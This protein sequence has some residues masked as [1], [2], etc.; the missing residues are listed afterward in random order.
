MSTIEH[1]NNKV[2]KIRI[3]QHKIHDLIKKNKLKI[4]PHMAFGY[5]ALSVAVTS[6]I[7]KKKDRLCLTHRN[8]SYNL[9]LTDSLQ[10]I[11]DELNLKKSGINNGITGS[12]NIINPKRGLYYTSSIL[13]NNLSIA[14]GIALQN[15]YKNN[16]V[17]FVTTGDGSMEE[18]SFYEVLLLART[19]NLK[20]LIIIENNNYAMASTIQDRRINFNIKKL[21]EALDVGYYK[22]QGN[23]VFKYFKNIS[24]IKKKIIK[25]SIPSIVEVKVKMFN[26]HYGQ[27]PGWPDDDKIIDSKNGLILRQNEEDPV[28]ISKKYLSKKI[29]LNLTRDLEKQTR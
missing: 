28:Y 13:G 18:G 24:K 10:P 2:C 23:D 25:K 14:M 8:I 26:N 16:G 20:L 3:F 9:S 12:M 7:D 6:I 1:L 11:V 15:K 17:T 27:T 4:V 21:A 19:L 5:E 29:F 22:I